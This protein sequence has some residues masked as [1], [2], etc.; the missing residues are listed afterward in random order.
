MI[1]RHPHGETMKIRSPAYIALL[2]II[3]VYAALYAPSTNPENTELIQRMYTT[4]VNPLIF[5]VF[6]LLGVWPM[7]FAVLV[8]DEAKSQGFPVYP[9]ILPS[10]FMGGFVYLIYFALRTRPKH[11]QPRT[12]L[13]EK[14]ETRGNMVLLGLITWALILYGVVYGDPAAYMQVYNTNGLVQI[15]SIDFVLFSI[16]ATVLIRDDMKRHN[17]YTNGRF[18]LYTMTSVIGSTLYLI[19]RTTSSG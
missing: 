17:R 6:N 19:D 13:Q 16:L 8:L 5:T 3:I 4:G 2:A 11:P 18:L 1:S 7:I 15:M 14:I 12:G 10:F 9:F